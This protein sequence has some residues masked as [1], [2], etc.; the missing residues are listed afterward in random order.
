M[1]ATGYVAKLTMDE[2]IEQFQDKLL[3]LDLKIHILRKYVDDVVC[4]LDNVRP[5][6]RLINGELVY[7]RSYEVEDMAKG[8][9]PIKTQ[10]EY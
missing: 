2:W 10:P 9:T 8:I 3:R 5:G 6:T 1:K 4:V 7:S